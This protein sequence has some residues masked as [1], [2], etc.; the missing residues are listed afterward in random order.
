MMFVPSIMLCS[1]LVLCSERLRLEV[2][3]FL[4][5][6]YTLVSLDFTDF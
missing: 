5:T 3:G 1:N 2:S 6:R 4:Y